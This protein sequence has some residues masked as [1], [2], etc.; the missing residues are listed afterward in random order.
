MQ[1]NTWSTPFFSL[2]LLGGTLTP[3]VND[4]EDMLEIRWND[5]MWIDVGFIKEENTYYVTTVADETLESW[6]N[7]LSVIEVKNRADL[8]AVLQKE[9]IRCR[10]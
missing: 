5:G 3:L 7:P 8:Q 9:I 2:E 10:S 6:N 1:K 4:D